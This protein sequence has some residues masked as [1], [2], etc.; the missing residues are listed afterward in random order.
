M[1][2][3]YFRAV[4]CVDPMIADVEYDVSYFMIAERW[5]EAGHERFFVWAVIIDCKL[6][7]FEDDWSANCDE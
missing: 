4:K 6:S 5:S 7:V 3:C 1:Y 2:I